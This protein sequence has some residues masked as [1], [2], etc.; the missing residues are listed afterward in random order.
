M[1]ADAVSAASVKPFKGGVKF[2]K[3]TLL[4]R[5]KYSM[6][7]SPYGKQ[8]A[9]M[10]PI[11]GQSLMEAGRM[12]K[13]S[14]KNHCHESEPRGLFECIESQQAAAEQRI[15][16]LFCVLIVNSCGDVSAKWFAWSFMHQ[17]LEQYYLVDIHQSSGLPIVSKKVLSTN[18]VV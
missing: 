8:K 6:K 1:V 18:K 12:Q 11:T 5:M 4:K 14:L 17:V 15:D 2:F 10:H 16:K 9:L 7:S 13:R 3:S